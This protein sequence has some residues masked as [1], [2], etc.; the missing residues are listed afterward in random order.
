MGADADRVSVCTVTSPLGS[1]EASR[2]A[3]PAPSILPLCLARGSQAGSCCVCGAVMLVTGRIKRRLASRGIGCPLFQ[4]HG[5]GGW[6]T[7]AHIS[8]GLS[9]G[10]HH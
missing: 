3:S 2:R 6:G 4:G 5:L 10:S 1:G 9:A 7:E 8:G